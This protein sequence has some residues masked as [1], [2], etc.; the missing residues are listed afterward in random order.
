[1]QHVTQFFLPCAHYTHDKAEM[2]S[3]PGMDNLHFFFSVSSGLVLERIPHVTA[4]T[5]V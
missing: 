2:G 1:M 3:H 4:T 5:T